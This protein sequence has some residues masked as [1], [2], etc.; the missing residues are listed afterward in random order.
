MTEGDKNAEGFRI[1]DRRGKGYVCYPVSGVGGL[2]GMKLHNGSCTHTLL[3]LVLNCPYRHV[4]PPP[5]PN[6]KQFS[7]LGS[8]TG[9]GG[10]D[11]DH[12]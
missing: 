3:L 4:I 8:E 1:G 6:H 11:S 10:A 12:A 7:H 5:N 2:G 9:E